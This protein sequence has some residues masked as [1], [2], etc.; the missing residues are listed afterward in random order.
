MC[1]PVRVC[2]TGT[3]PK[4]RTRPRYACPSLGEGAGGGCKFLSGLI[5]APTLA[6]ASLGHPSLWEGL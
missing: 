3:V 5:D 2:G 1:P 6:V 4:I